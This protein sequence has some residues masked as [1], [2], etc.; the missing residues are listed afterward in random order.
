M[1]VGRWVDRL[2]VSAIDEFVDRLDVYRLAAAKVPKATLDGVLEA[3]EQ[4][5]P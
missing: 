1:G 4:E 2:S 3:I 5:I